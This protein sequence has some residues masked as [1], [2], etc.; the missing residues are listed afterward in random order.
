MKE[1]FNN[2]KYSPG[3]K[4]S[5]KERHE[6]VF[7]YRIR[8]LFFLVLIIS[9]IIFLKLYS[10]Q[11][12]SFASFKDLSEN[13]HSLF[14]TLI[15]KRGE[16][17]LRDKSSIYPVAVNQEVKMAYAVPKEIENMDEVVDFIADTLELNREEIREKLKNPEDMYEVLKHRLNDGEI[18]KINSRKLSGIRLADE[19]YRYYPAGELASNVLGFVGWNEN[20]FGGKYGIEK[21]FE[22]EIKGQEGKIFQSRDAIGRWIAIGDRILEPA[23]DGNNIVLTID[24]I[25][26]FETEK[27][28]KGAIKKFEADS[29]TIVVMEP[30]TGKILALANYPNFNPNKYGET[31]DMA[32]FRNIAVSDAYEP[33]SIFKTFTLAAALDSGKITPDTTY[34]DTGLVQEAGYSIQNS[35]YKAYGRQTMTEVLEKSLNTGAIF[36]EKLIGNKNFSDYAHRFG[37]GELTGIELF[38]ESGGNINNLK[39]L[40]SDIQFFTAAFGQGITITPLQL[41]SAYN[42]IA[43]GG[44]L[45]KPQIVEKIIHPDNDDEEIRKPQEIRRAISTQAAQDISKMLVSVVEKGHGKRAGVPGYLVGG[46]TGTAQVASQE[47]KGYEEGK[48]IGS[49]GGFA[50]A[51]NPKFTIVVRI[52]NPKTVEWAESSAAPAFGEL[53]KF[54]LEYYNTEPTEEYTQKELD[55]FNAT[56]NLK[57]FLAQKEKEEA[58]KK[59]E[60]EA[61]EKAE[62]EKLEKMK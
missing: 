27:I 5:L 30:I 22:S 57:E 2:R 55:E 45:M 19:N 34:V 46:K 12:L 28:L 39:N 13:Q 40:K 51:D 29:G 52:N 16:I 4:C 17:F 31:E 23:K 37:F 44:V 21:Y 10:L 38:G 26:Q 24:H 32:A 7:N 15:P 8:A 14:K 49:F 58:E 61:K 59:K 62:K 9:G 18:S 25:A 35:D 48:N 1:K 6:T 60:L 54:L 41:A 53:M 43:S 11:V 3:D 47:K 42:A 50:P 33:G 56:H 36:A 20:N